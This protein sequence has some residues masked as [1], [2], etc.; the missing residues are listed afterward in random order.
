MLRKFLDSARSDPVL[1]LCWKARRTNATPKQQMAF[2]TFQT[3]WSITYN[4]RYQLSSKPWNRNVYLLCIIMY[5]QA[6][7]YVSRSLFLYVQGNQ[8]NVNL[9]NKLRRRGEGRGRITQ[10]NNNAETH[11]QQP[12]QHLAADTATAEL[13]CSEEQSRSTST[14]NNVTLLLH[15]IRFYSSPFPFPFHQ[16]QK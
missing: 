9:G 7:N 16:K 6:Y 12:L 10:K 4:K 14:T 13:A 11:T 2:C 15:G 8:P 1:K 5:Q 3:K